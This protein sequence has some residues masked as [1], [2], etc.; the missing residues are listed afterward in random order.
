[1]VEQYKMTCCPE[2]KY[3][4]NRELPEAGRTRPALYGLCEVA[5]CT[6]LFLPRLLPLP[7]R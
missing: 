4:Q 2:G 1:M 7:R 5:R 3:S 6:L